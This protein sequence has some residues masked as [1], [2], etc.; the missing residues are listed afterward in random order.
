MLN[1]ATV[2][3]QLKKE[4]ERAQKEVDGLDTALNALGSLVS[5][6][7]GSTGGQTV[8]KKRKTMSAAA[9]KRIAAAQRARWAKWKAAKR[10]K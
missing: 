9:R 5:Q 10:S 8:A 1:L 6:N 4:R 3:G 2:L 7:R